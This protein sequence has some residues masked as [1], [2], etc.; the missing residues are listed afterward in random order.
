MVF[1]AM[2]NDDNKVALKISYC[3]SGRLKASNT[4]IGVMK[5]IKKWY[6]DDKDDDAGLKNIV[7]PISFFPIP[8]FG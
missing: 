8:N 1:S 2:T 7:E 4:E 6:D 5:K 3:E